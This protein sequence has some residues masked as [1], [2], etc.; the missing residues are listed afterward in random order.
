MIHLLSFSSYQVYAT[1]ANKHVT[2]CQEELKSVFGMTHGVMV[3]M[4]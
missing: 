3:I 2:T 1:T 4:R